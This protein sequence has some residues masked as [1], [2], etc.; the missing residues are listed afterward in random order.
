MHERQAGHLSLAPTPEDDGAGASPEPDAE[1]AA[2][3]AQPL[4]TLQ[5]VELPPERRPGWS[6]LTL[7]AIVS[8]LAALLL[9]GAAVI[10]PDGGSSSAASSSDSPALQQAVALLAAPGSE[11]IQ[12]AGSL[13]RLVLLVGQTGNGVLVLNGLGPAPEGKAYQAWLTPPGPGKTVSAGLFDGSEQFVPLT[14]RV[15]RGAQVSVTLEDEGGVA[16]PSK[17]PRL[18]AVRPADSAS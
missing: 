9:G 12:F 4:P 18:Y 2:T 13:G 3:T 10:W 5:P 11:R 15:E 14:R 6:N 7:L 16:M 1:P 8:G 17:A